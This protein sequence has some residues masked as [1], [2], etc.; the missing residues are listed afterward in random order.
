MVMP[1]ARLTAS[2]GPLVGRIG[3][4]LPCPQT[5]DSGMATASNSARRTP[6]TVRGAVATALRA[7]RSAG[8]LQPW[9]EPGAAVALKLA[10]ALSRKDVSTQ[11]LVRLSAS[12]RATL[13][14]L[15]LAPTD[16]PPV[17]PP[18][19]GGSG[20]P[21]AVDRELA[22]IVGSGPTLGDQTH[23]V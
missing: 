6:Q 13:E 23:P 4:P 19:E 18:D 22:A 2:N 10:A 17:P 8:R 11:E 12:L 5:Y 15:P 7:A 21:D 16:M 3:G 1:G 9:H 20:E 14:A